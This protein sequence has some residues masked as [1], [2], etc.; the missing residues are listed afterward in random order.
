MEIREINIDNYDYNLPEERIAQYPLK[1][2]DRSKLLVMKNGS[3]NQDIFMNI[4]YH[5]PEVSFLVFNNSKVIRAR[6]L[7]GK[8]TGAR[9]EVFCLEPLLPNDYES[10]FMSKGPV[11]WKCIVGNLKK[12]KNGIIK[13]GFKYKGEHK[14]IQAE[15]ISPDEGESWRIRLTWNTDIPFAE[16][17]DAAGHIPLPPYI[18]RPDEASDSVSYQTVYSR[19]RGS[20]AAPTAGLHFTEN[21]L[22]S[23]KEKGIESAEITL[24]VG[25]GTFQPVKVRNA[26]EHEMHCEHFIL[27]AETLEKLIRNA[28]HVIAVGTT[29]VRTLESIY[30]LGV[31]LINKAVDKKSTLSLEQWEAYGL[32]TEIPVNEAL[33]A[34][35]M[36]MEAENILSLYASTS[37]MIVPGYKFRIINGIITNFHQPRSTLLLLVSAWIGEKWKDAYRFALENNF[38]FLSY[39]DSSLLLP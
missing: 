8:D 7:F 31:K 4:G 20:V 14:I 30:W 1:D 36:F 22:E 32:N 37:I 19:I 27:T 3:L 28:G 10:S 17:L 15:K 25:A 29:S 5:L 11:E 39:G 38:R 23:L 35:K 2:R 26:A 24:H 13:A 6:L 9:I 16:V 12:W 18:A 21:V 33:N 34:L